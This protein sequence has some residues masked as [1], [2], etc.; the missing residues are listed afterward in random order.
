MLL[1]VVIVIILNACPGPSK[2]SDAEKARNVSESG[3]S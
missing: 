3:K 1:V 2:G